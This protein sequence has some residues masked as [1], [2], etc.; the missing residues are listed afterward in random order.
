MNQRNASTGFT[1][2]ELLVTVTMVAILVAV[3]VPSFESSLARNGVQSHQR[4]LKADFGFARA[5]SIS[6]GAPVVICGSANGTTCNASNDWSTGWL[7]F[8]DDGAGMG[9]SAGDGSRNGTEEILR[10]FDH[11]GDNTVTAVDSVSNAANV[12]AFNQRGYL[13]LRNGLTLERPSE[14]VTVGICEADDRAAF[15]RAVV[16]DITGR[17]AESYDSDDNGI[18]EDVNGTD[19]GC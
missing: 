4:A 19:L 9:A 17:V 18:F 7:V 12:I 10:V 8:V 6:R 14:R 15:A 13:L 11:D 16:V 2:I 1:L 3:A 5:E